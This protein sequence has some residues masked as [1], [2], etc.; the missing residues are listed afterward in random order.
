MMHQLGTVQSAS[1]TTPVLN[2]GDQ[3]KTTV[4]TFSACVPLVLTASA[5]VRI[6]LYATATAQL[7]DLLRSN[8]T[9]PSPGTQQGI[10]LDVTIDSTPMT[11][12]LTP[13]LPCANADS[14]QNAL[15]YV[16]I[17]NMGSAS[18]AITSTVQYLVLQI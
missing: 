8:T 2:P 15:S 17:T 9:P 5:A 14:P 7:S 3:Y 1:I 6:E 12:I 13:S 11:W 10:L 16:T 18:M 4:H